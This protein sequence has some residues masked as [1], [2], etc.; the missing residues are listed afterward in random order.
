VH[1]SSLTPKLGG[2]LPR[3]TARGVG[4][5][6]AAVALVLAERL[7]G[8]VALWPFIAVLAI[9]LV[10]APALVLARRHSAAAAQVRAMVIPPLVAVGDRSDLRI[11]LAND[12]DGA[13]PPVHLDW[14]GEHA[15][16]A[17][18]TPA[19]LPRGL[20]APEAGRLMRWL[21]LGAGQ[22]SSSLHA[23]P[24]GRRGVFTIGP[25]RLWVHD[26]LGLFAMRV[27]T[28][29]AATLTVHPVRG[30]TPGTLPPLLAA[31]RPSQA[32]ERSSHASDDDPGG[33]LCGLRPYVPGDRLHLLSWPVEAHYGSL[34]VH[35]FQPDHGALHRILLD[36]RAGVHRRSAFEHVLSLIYALVSEVS[37]SCATELTTFSGDRIAVTS[38]PDDMVD[39]LTYLARAQPRHMSSVPLE[40]G[41]LPAGERVSALVTTSTARASLPPLPADIAVLVVT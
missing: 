11:V 5:A 32:P 7:T 17:T 15:R 14:P 18:R 29:A 13:L 38:A 36:D 12:G 35:Q 27:A 3:P 21:P 4:V 34:M 25:L 22:S 41:L 9:P 1:P 37:A 39:L 26:P 16:S 23:L 19:P 30:P 24:T 33:E 2:D 28:A 10:T 20:L 6:V 40:A 31:E 8:I